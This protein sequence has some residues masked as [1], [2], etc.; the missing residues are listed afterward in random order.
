MEPGNCNHSV[1]REK[2]YQ[3]VSKPH[4][5]HPHL[6]LCI[7]HCLLWNWTQVTKCI[8]KQAN[9]WLWMKANIWPRSVMI[10]N[11]DYHYN[12]TSGKNKMLQK[13]MWLSSGVCVHVFSSAAVWKRCLT[14]AWW[15]SSSLG[16]F[17]R[18]S[19]PMTRWHFNP[20]VLHICFSGFWRWSPT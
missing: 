7:T 15:I 20:K 17:R 5:N 12:E 10:E 9:W 13:C 2:H 4:E 14:S 19:M 8:C 6:Y 11:L 1:S 16:H 3:Q 18:K